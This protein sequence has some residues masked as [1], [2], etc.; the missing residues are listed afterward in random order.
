MTLNKQQLNKIQ[1]EI[2]KRLSDTEK[3]I[4][5]KRY[6]PALKIG[7]MYGEVVSRLDNLINILS[8][9]EINAAYYTERFKKQS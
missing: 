5:Q 2:V 8:S 9:D 3:E 6:A 7:G 4:V 1:T